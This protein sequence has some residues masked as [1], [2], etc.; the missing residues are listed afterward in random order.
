M[1]EY[2]RAFI[3]K[4]KRGTEIVRFLLLKKSLVFWELIGVFFTKIKENRRGRGKEKE[5][6]FAA[7]QINRNEQALKKRKSVVAK[8]H[9][10]KNDHQHMLEGEEVYIW[11]EVSR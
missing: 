9:E 5:N 11:E 10:H 8:Q 3:S 2:R 7:T 6:S 4:S 1:L